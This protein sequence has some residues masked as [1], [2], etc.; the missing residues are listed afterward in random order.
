[1]PGD[2]LPRG[3]TRNF[4]DAAEL[5]WHRM[6]QC[7]PPLC[8]TVDL[9]GTRHAYVNPH[10]DPHM[11]QEA[12]MADVNIQQT[13]PEAP[14]SGGGGGAGWAVAV[15]VLLAVVAWFVFGGGL[16]KTSTY[17]ADVKIQTPGAPSGGS[18]GGSVAPPSGGS[19]PK[20]P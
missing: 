2:F 1:M 9:A 8:L 15:V 10:T 17:R 11:S 14:R 5:I 20:T 4:D 19:V 6:Q 3:P 16:H 13:P 18:A 7:G 12:S